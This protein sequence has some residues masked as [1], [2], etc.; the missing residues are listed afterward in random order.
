MPSSLS[1]FRCFCQGGISAPVFGTHVLSALA[2]MFLGSRGPGRGRLHRRRVGGRL[3][4]SVV[5]A[6]LVVCV[7][8]VAVGVV[9]VVAADEVRAAAA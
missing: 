3:Q 8:V 2:Y 4:T 7:V 6:V 5:A 9:V 1:L